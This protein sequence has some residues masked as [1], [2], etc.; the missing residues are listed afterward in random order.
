MA[1]PFCTLQD[2]P[3][4]DVPR[5][6]AH[7]AQEEVILNRCFQKWHVDCFKMFLWHGIYTV[8]H[9]RGARPCNL[10]PHVPIGPCVGCTT[11]TWHGKDPIRVSSMR[12]FMNNHCPVSHPSGF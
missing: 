12:T 8:N 5:P 9:L 10:F 6:I 4:K 3:R 11:K 1:G 2:D 7:S